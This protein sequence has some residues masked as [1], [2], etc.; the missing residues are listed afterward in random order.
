MNAS[1]WC[2]TTCFLVLCCAANAWPDE[3]D[4]LDSRKL[5]SMEISARLTTKIEVSPDSQYLLTANGATGSSSAVYLGPFMVP[6]GGNSEPA[7]ICVYDIASASRTEVAS[8]ELDSQATPKCHFA[9]D[10]Q[11]IIYEASDGLHKWNF[12]NDSDEQI[13][14][15]G[16]YLFFNGG[17]ILRSEA[18]DPLTNT[19]AVIQMPYMRRTAS[20]DG[21]VIADHRPVFP[22]SADELDALIEHD[23]QTSEPDE[24]S[25]TSTGIVV[26]H[27]FSIGD[28]L[29]AMSRS[30]YVRTTFYHHP[31]KDRHIHICIRRRRPAVSIA[32]GSGMENGMLSSNGLRYADFCF[33]NEIAVWD[34]LNAKVL[35]RWK[36]EGYEVDDFLLSPDGRILAMW[37]V[38][39]E[40]SPEDAKDPAALV[41]GRV[42]KRFGTSLRVVEVDS[43]CILLEQVIPAGKT[44]LGGNDAKAFSPDGE[45][46]YI[47]NSTLVSPR[48]TAYSLAKSDDEEQPPTE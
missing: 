23:L 27:D 37:F 48:V 45:T 30:A 38:T 22:W 32:I 4:T 9:A 6:L 13:A 5:W 42:N 39:R 10:N 7:R 35:G 8:I 34:T 44:T 18:V 24:T 11:T 36:C 21:S 29:E 16:S 17:V 41:I 47:V 20:S 46:L 33:D 3:P 2:L 26:E 1:R 19:P 40:E 15:Q 43:G 14:E 31:E 12:I 28:D 25:S